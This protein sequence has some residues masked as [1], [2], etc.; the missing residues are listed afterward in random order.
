M[1]TDNEK[2]IDYEG[3]HFT[4]YQATQRQRQLERAIRK[5]KRRI[6][7]D[8]SIGDKKKLQQDQIKYQVLDQEYKRFSKAAGLR[9]QHERMEMTGFGPKQAM[10]AENTYLQSQSK[11]NSVEIAEKPDII[12]PSK[13]KGGTYVH[14][15]TRLDIDKYKCVSDKITTDEV[16]ITDERIQHIRERHPNDFERYERYMR[17]IIQSPDYILEA[18]KPNTAFL[19]KQ[20][21][22]ADERFQLI[23][24]L[25]V[26]GDPAE[27]KN[28]VITFLKVEEKRYKRYLR[29]KN[30]LYK[31]E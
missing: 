15:I 24:R 20:I 23:L 9:L 11:I 21:V 30:I 29:T 4:M 3:R 7:V 12:E 19:L 8:E 27:Y 25:A 26:Q 14:Y 16:I 13:E 28:S 31:P 1:R 22:E 17:E 6:L 5:Q 2:G 18:N 10:A